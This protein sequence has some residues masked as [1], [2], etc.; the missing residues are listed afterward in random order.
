MGE[1]GA[2]GHA[3]GGRAWWNWG[4]LLAAWSV[5]DPRHLHQLSMP[6]SFPETGVQERSRRQLEHGEEEGEL[7]EEVSAGC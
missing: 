4:G 5:A 2:S 7:S 6:A 1:R 3:G